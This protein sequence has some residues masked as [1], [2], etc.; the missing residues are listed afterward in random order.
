MCAHVY[1]SNGADLP[2]AY[3]SC[4]RRLADAMAELQ[5]TPTVVV[6]Q[7]MPMAQAV[8][9][10]Q[11][12]STYSAQAVPV[13]QVVPPAQRQMQR[14]NTMGATMA[15]FRQRPLWQKLLTGGLCFVMICVAIFFFVRSELMGCGCPEQSDGWGRRL[16]AVF[17]G[18]LLQEHNTCFCS[19]DVFSCSWDCGQNCYRNGIQKLCSEVQAQEEKEMQQAEQEAGEQEAADA[20][21]GGAVTCPGK[22]SS[23]YCDCGGDCGGS[24]CDCAEAKAASCC[25]NAR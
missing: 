18:R 20:A 21:A 14:Q 5:G 13:A 3:L 11:T 7:A 9:M 16:N 25:N 4:P 19:G 10:G 15:Q 12:T 22:S 23:D 17:P 2:P 8:P 6:A 1:Q 24:Y